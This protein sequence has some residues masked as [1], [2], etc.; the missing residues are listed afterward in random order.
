M[1]S[2]SQARQGL[3]IHGLIRKSMKVSRIQYLK[4]A[5]QRLQ[6]FIYSV[7]KY[8]FSELDF[9]KQFRFL[10]K[11]KKWIDFDLKMKLN[12]TIIIMA[13]SSIHK[14]KKS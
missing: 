1:R 5:I 3:I 2:C 4:K 9:K 11:L 8:L 12:K 13:N 7:G 6:Q 10:H 14:S